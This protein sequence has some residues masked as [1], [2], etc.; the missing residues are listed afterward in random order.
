[1]KQRALR[2]SVG[3]IVLIALL[4]VGGE[5]H[6]QNT[7][8]SSPALDS[9]CYF[10]QFGVPGEIDT[11]YGAV[12]GQGLGGNLIKNLGPSP[13]GSPG[14][15]IVGDLDRVNHDSISGT[16]YQAMT[17]SGFNL[18]NLSG[19]RMILTDQQIGSKP[20]FAHLRTGKTLDLFTG[21][22]IFWANDA[23]NYDSARVTTLGTYVQGIANEERPIIPAY[24]AHLTSDTIDDIL[25][26]GYIPFADASKDTVFCLLFKGGAALAAKDTACEDTTAVVGPLQMGHDG[27]ALQAD[28]RGTG[29]DDL[30][31]GD[32]YN[33]SSGAIRWTYC[34]FRNDP[35][36]ALERFAK[37]IVRD[38]LMVSWELPNGVEAGPAFSM[39]LL[40]KTA[41]DSSLDL[42]MD[43]G[44]HS[45]IYSDDS[46]VVLRGGPDFGSRRIT[47]D[48]AA[49]EIRNP[50]Y[51]DARFYFNYY[52][53]SFHQFMFMDA[54]DMTGTGNHVLYLNADN[55]AHVTFDHFYITGKALDEKTDMFVAGGGGL[56]ADTL[57][58][59]ADKYGDIVFSDPS[60][61]SD[62]D[63]VNYGKQGAG[64][65]R[66]YHGSKDIP[67]HLNPRWAGVK[68]ATSI[69]SATL[70]LS[71]NPAQTSTV[72]D[73]VWPVS[74]AVT[75]TIRNILG[76]A[77]L[78]KAFRLEAGESELHLSLGILAPG[79]YYV[80]IE[81][82]A[83]EA[84]ARFAIVR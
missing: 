55:D 84:R 11:I 81:G 77:V 51:L 31:V 79:V 22:Q 25:L 78:T 30:M 72:A 48:S 10:P 73:M 37:A 76:A 32:Y 54:G 17:G 59:D 64:T 8:F 28:Y 23:G 67:V 62:S 58:A 53:P 24:I 82:S 70:S 14:N 20:I 15:I 66:L 5:A 46:I 50:K 80:S 69:A 29:R 21:A 60:Y 26:I 7:P 3:L 42:L 9:N 12:Y 40:P 16:Y 45:N 56:D 19:K 1:M 38:T 2:R 13:D 75:L 47:I 65:L 63:L 44:T 57:T 49:F 61:T 18:H 68:Q 52:W 34:Y 71:P 33:D 4:F 41:G 74:E 43:V 39:R 6:S 36:F 35:P 83:G 27:G